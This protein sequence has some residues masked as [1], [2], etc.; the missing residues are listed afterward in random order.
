MLDSLDC[1][2]QA[3]AQRAWKE[4]YALLSAA[5]AETPLEGRDLE[6]MATAAYLIG[7]DEAS[8][9]AWTRAYEWLRTRDR[10]RAARCAFR[11]VLQ[12]LAIGDWARGGGWLSTAERLLDDDAECPERGLLLVLVARTHAKRG[13]FDAAYDAFT[14]VAALARTSDDAE[15]NAFRLLGLAQATA[16]RGESAA[17][18]ALFDEAMVAV[19]TDALSPIS[20]GVIYCAVIE[21]CYA[22]LDIARAREW[23][24]ALSRWCADQPDL[25]PF[26]GHCLVHRAETLRLTGDWS[27]AIAQAGQVCAVAS[28]TANQPGTSAPLDHRMRAYPIGAA[29][30]EMAE[31]H[32]MQ[33]HFDDAEKAYRQAHLH[34]RSPEPGLA[35]LRLAEGRVDDAVTAIQRIRGQSQKRAVRAGVL[36][37]CVD[38]MLA[39]QVHSAA[40]DAADELAALAEAMP[41]PY[42]RALSAQ[43]KGAILLTEGKPRDALE[44]LRAAWV[45]WQALEVPYEAARVRVAMGLS[46]RQLGDADAAELEFDA[47][48]RVFLR[49]GAAPDVARANELLAPSSPA[50]ARLLTPRELQVIRLIAAGDSNR[51][52]ARE[53][54]ISERTVDRHVSNI[55]TKLDL[56]SRSAAT[57]YAYEHGLLR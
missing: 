2:R 50:G 8:E 33:G 18:M 40:R 27:N 29:F 30:Y 31:I 35:L 13:D 15:L 51:A 19:V 28:Q 57:A 48:R 6:M 32:R 38:I 10:R 37:A 5:D 22:I 45:E 20:A 55:L 34:G 46:W 41:L 42:L 17:A 1:G 36:S 54:A 56:S 53:L 49:L 7:K 24:A 21:A 25:L 44:T 12:L 11:L 16:S 47:A 52:I 14:R 23:T 9:T 39:A 4:A 43:A 3:F 26:R